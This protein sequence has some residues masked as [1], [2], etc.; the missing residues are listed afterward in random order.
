MRPM[1]Q[2]AALQVSTL[3][4]LSGP[5]LLAGGARYATGLVVGG[6][7]CCEATTHTHHSGGRHRK[8]NDAN[9]VGRAVSINLKLGFG[10]RLGSRSAVGYAR[11]FVL[12]W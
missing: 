6:G 8:R 2:L 3:Q 4:R 11:L 5:Q 10:G 12:A 1:L 9:T 7:R